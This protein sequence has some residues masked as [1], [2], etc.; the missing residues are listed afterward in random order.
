MNWI[1][2]D[3]LVK[4]TSPGGNPIIGSA[5]AATPAILLKLS[6][7]S[8]ASRYFHRAQAPVVLCQRFV[9]ERH[10]LRRVQT[11]EGCFDEVIDT[12][13]GT[14]VKRTPAPCVAQCG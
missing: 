12:F 5:N 9:D 6:Q 10:V 1:A 7:P 2:L 3:D 11:P 4:K 8:A 14:V 13:N